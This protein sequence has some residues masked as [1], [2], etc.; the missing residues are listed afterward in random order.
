MYFFLMLGMP[1]GFIL[2]LLDAYPKSEYTAARRAFTRGLVA[3]VPLWLVARLLGA[4]VPE[5]FGT[6]LLTFH[7]WADRLLPYAALPAL[8]YL[9]FYRVGETLPVGAAQRRLTAF[10]AGALAPVGLCETA[11]IWGNAAPYPLFLL[12]LLLGAICILMPKAVFAIHSGYGAGLAST[13]ALVAAATFAAS[14]CPYL[15]LARLW[16]L[17]LAV[18][19]LAGAGSWYFSY[20]ELRRHPPQPIGE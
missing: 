14:A 5:S 16:P 4:I 2:L 3:F 1:L 7:E 20:P 15:I 13:L 10:Y 8:A 12:P 9:V 17:A 19:A 18:V 6:F 11:R